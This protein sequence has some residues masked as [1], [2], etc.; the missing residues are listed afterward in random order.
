MAKI[1]IDLSKDEDKIVEVPGLCPEQEELV[2][3]EVE[4]PEAIADASL[5][6]DEA[7]AAVFDEL[8][9]KAR[10]LTFCGHEF[11]EDEVS[12]KRV[13]EWSYTWLDDDEYEVRFTAKFEAEDH[14]DE[15]DCKQTRS[16]KVLFEEDEDPVVT[17]I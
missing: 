5:Y 16:Y 2:C 3:P 14:S 12:I 6:L 1:Q 8:G 7:T 13:M 15:R 4:A 17:R 11:D 9:D 10:F